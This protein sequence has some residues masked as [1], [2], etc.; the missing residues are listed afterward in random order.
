M[1]YVAAVSIFVISVMAL[2]AEILS[3]VVRAL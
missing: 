2:G 3:H 1:K